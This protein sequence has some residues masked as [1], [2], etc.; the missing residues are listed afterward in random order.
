M[1]R[2]LLLPRS[3]TS[4]I[5]VWLNRRGELVITKTRKGNPAPITLKI[6]KPSRDPEIPIKP[7]KIRSKGSVIILK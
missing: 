5:E 2:L 6:Y 7:V 3:P 1:K 4:R